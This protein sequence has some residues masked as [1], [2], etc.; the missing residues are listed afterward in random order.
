M[1]YF[2]LRGCA[3]FKKKRIGSE[4]HLV[5]WRSGCKRACWLSVWQYSQTLHQIFA[6]LNQKL[7]N[8]I[9]IYTNLYRKFANLISI[10][11]NLNQKFANLMLIFANLMKSKQTWL[12]TCKPNTLFVEIKWSLFYLFSMSSFLIQSLHC[13]ESHVCFHTRKFFV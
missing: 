10:Y 4:E 3:N 8:L 5:V 2:W 11:T 12:N 9:L 7:A 1:N 13:H 6:N